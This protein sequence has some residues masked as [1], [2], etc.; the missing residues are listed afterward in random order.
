M[1][2][3][4]VPLKA[5]SS[6]RSTIIRQIELLYTDRQTHQQTTIYLATHAHLSINM[7]LVILENVDQTMCLDLSFVTGRNSSLF[8]QRKAIAKLALIKLPLMYYKLCTV[9]CSVV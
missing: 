8:A 4:F 9:C 7:Y 3:Y 2:A 1:K 6:D 5:F